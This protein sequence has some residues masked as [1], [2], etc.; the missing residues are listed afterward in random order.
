M[1]S[2]TWFELIPFL[3]QYTAHGYIHILNAALATLVS[4]A[5]G[6]AISFKLKRTKDLD[7]PERAFNLRNFFELISSL[8]FSLASE[9]MGEKNAKRFFPMLASVFFFVLINDLLGLIPGFLP[10]TDNINTTFACGVFIFIY[11]NYAG[12]KEH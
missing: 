12:I 9:I 3:K 2:F 4:I 11:Y 6:L 5:L 10:P 8:L 7:I 1:H